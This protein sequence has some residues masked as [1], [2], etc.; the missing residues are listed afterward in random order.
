MSKIELAGPKG[1]LDDVIELLQESGTLQIDTGEFSRLEKA[2]EHAIKSLM[3][4]ERTISER[5]FLE[6]LR[7]RIEE[8]FSYFPE[9][10]LRVSYLQPRTIIDSVAKMLERH[11]QQCRE[12]YQG[13][14]ALHEEIVNLN[15]YGPF[16]E[17]V[18]RLIKNNAEVPGLDFIG[19]TIQ[20]PEA[21]E[22]VRG[23]LSTLTTG[24]FE[25]F[26]TS[27]SDGSIVGVIILRKEESKNIRK[28][29]GDEYVPELT[30][31]P[32][33]SKLSFSEKRAY[34]RK[35]ISEISTKEYELN[36]E[37]KKFAL[38]WGP[39]YAMVREWVYDRLSVLKASTAAFETHMC[40]FIQGWIPS[41]QVEQLESEMDKKFSGRVILA[42]KEIREEDLERIPVILKNP[43]YFQPFEIFTRLLPLP[44]YTSYDPTTFL[45]IFFP[46]IFGMIL[47][48]AGYALLLLLISVF[49]IK[50]LA[51][52]T[53]RDAAKILF[54]ASIYAVFFG[55]LYG[56]FFGEIGHEL[57]GMKTLCIERRTAV[58]PMIYFSITVGLAH[59]VLGLAL[60]LITAL[61]RRTKKEALYRLINILMILCI[62]ALVA[63]FFGLFPG[64][65]K[66]PAIIAIFILTPLL[67]F[68]GGLLAPFELLKSLGNIIS[69]ARIM[70][71]GLTSVLLAFVANRIA[72]MI[73]D[74]VIGVAVA[75][76]IHLLN[77][78]LGIFSPTI[79]SLRLHYVEFFGKFLEHGGRDFEP[80]KKIR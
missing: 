74:I 66:K 76:L 22:N 52:K 27:V 12:M 77:I 45:A 15:R 1:L 67:L 39:I 4:D 71:I 33:L 46:L 78:V 14:E 31:P 3:P 2:E 62:L 47:G 8:L 75:G 41:K 58:I 51:R 24:K 63:S 61:K 13:K 6:D 16:L 9:V 29:L 68:T 5:F 28:V 34:L 10:R 50:K 57:F 60:G 19:I 25:L 65:F 48:D 42:E 59:I 26:T 80:L 54:I 17:T 79:H 35:R 53:F 18:A 73:G 36:S 44:R 56:E 69:Y 37:L 23:I 21:L 32:A 38:R 7:V 40:F 55:I 70:A 49:L 64:L 30:F 43:S 72:G 20:E 11:L